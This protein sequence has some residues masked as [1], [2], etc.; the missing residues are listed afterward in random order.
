MAVLFFEDATEN[1]E[2]PGAAFAFSG[3]EAGLGA[4]D[5]FLEV[6][7]LATLGVLKLFFPRLEILLESFLS[8]QQAVEF[9]LRVHGRS[10]V[11]STLHLDQ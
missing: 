1:D 8:G 3:G 2:A 9:F 10:M 7:A 5:L 6:G 4:T 11:A